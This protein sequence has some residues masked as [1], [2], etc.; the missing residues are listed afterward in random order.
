[1]RQQGQIAPQFHVPHVNSSALQKR[2]ATSMSLWARSKCLLPVRNASRFHL[3]P[4]PCPN[5]WSRTERHSGSCGLLGQK[6][7]E[8][9]APFHRA[10]HLPPR[11]KQMGAGQ[12]SQL[13]AAVCRSSVLCV[14]VCV[15]VHMHAAQCCSVCRTSQPAQLL[16]LLLPWA[17]LLLPADD[18]L[19][20]TTIC[21]WYY[22]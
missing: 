9:P 1:M 16:L 4:L 14:C 10:S 18:G 12:A 21:C 2:A 11:C 7:A 17:H 8:L 5:Q 19:W 6:P 15:C 20:P 3:A 22:C 13:S